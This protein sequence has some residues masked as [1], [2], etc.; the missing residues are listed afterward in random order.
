MHH[1]DPCDQRPASWAVAHVSLD[2]PYGVANLLKR[3]HAVGAS[4]QVTGLAA[5]AAVG[6][7]VDRPDGVAS[8]L[9][10]MRAAGAAEQVTQLTARLPAAGLFTAHPDYG[11]W[12]YRFGREPS[13]RP[14]L[15]WDWTDLD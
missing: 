15:A 9:D 6:V 2:D 7:A 11:T 14:A 8:L 4:G 5:R 12:P 3:L 1:L 10:R 13:G